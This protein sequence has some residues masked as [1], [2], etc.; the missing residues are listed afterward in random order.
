MPTASKS[1]KIGSGTLRLSAA[2]IRLLNPNTR[3]CPIFRSRRDAEI[4]K[5]IYRRVPILI[6]T[7]REG[8]TGNPW[9][10]QF[11]RMFH[12]TNDAELF[13]EADTLK[14]DGFKLK[15]NRWIKGK[16]V[17][18]PV[19][20]A[21]MLQDLRPSRGRRCDRQI[22]LGAAGANR[23]DD[24]WSAIRIPNTWRCPVLGRLHEVE[25]TCLTWAAHSGFQGR[26]EPNESANDDCRDVRRSRAFI[27]SLR[28]RSA[29]DTAARS[30]NVSVGQSQRIRLRLLHAAEDRQ[31]AL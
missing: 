30:S 8:P 3:T 17:F 11:K 14:A 1:W 10:I 24:R 26:H 23:K 25:R 20:E 4:T 2:D 13:R 15:G 16:K 5:A 9:G 21:K 31:R 22:E 27:N 19:Y 29:R 7:N 6:D 18:L 28:H 12:Q